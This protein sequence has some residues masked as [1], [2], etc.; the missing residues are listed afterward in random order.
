M[1]CGPEG[2]VWSQ[3][4]GSFGCSLYRRYE[5]KEDPRVDRHSRSKSDSSGRPED[6]AQ[7]YQV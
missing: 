4:K 3:G 6:G 2:C 7:G 1:R 5:S